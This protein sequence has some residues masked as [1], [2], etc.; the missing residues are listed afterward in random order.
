MENSSPFRIKKHFPYLKKSQNNDT[1]E[2][3]ST[4][5]H[6]EPVNSSGGLEQTVGRGQSQV[7]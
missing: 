6:C 4:D 1:T 7:L 3:E 2:S 5:Q